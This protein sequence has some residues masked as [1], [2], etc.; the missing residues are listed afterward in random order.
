MQTLCRNISLDGQ[1]IMEGLDCH[2][3]LANDAY[4]PKYKPQ[5]PVQVTVPCTAQAGLLAAGKIEDP[6]FEM[7]NE[8]ILW[9]EEKEWWYFR[10]FTVPSDIKGQRYQLVF[11][12]ITYRA[13]VFLDGITVGKLEGTFLRF[14]ID[15]TKFA[16]PGSTH[17]LA[18]RLRALEDSSKDRPGGEVKRGMVRSSGVVPPFSYWWNW[19]P[20]LVPVGI[21]KSVHL[22]IDGGVEIR[23]PYVQTKIS[24]DECIEAEYADITVSVDA[25]CSLKRSEDIV[26][27]G[28]IKGDGFDDGE[29]DLREFYTI[30][31]GFNGK[32]VIKTRMIRPRL[33]WP[34]GMG[35]HPLYT[36]ELRVYDREGN[37]L[38][39]VSTEFGVREIT[40]EKNPDDQWTLET[41]KQSNRLWSYVGNP[42]PWIYVVN[43]K[44]MFVR[45]SNW[46]PMDNM[47]RFEE[48]RY[49]TYLDQIEDSNLNLLRVWAGGICETETFYRICNR[50]GILCWAETWFSCSNYP[51]MSHDLFIENAIDM[52]KCIRNHPS[53]AMWS[54]GNEYNPDAPENKDLVDKIGEAVKQYDPDRRFRRGSPYKG[55]R[56]GGLLILPTRTSNKYNG[57]ILNGDQRLTIFRAEVAIARSVPCVESL[58]KFLGEDHLWPLD[59]P[60]TKEIWQYHHAVIKEEE[61]DAKEYGCTDSLER[62][63]MSTQIYHG[64]VHRHNMEHCRLTKWHNSGCMQWQAQA[65]WPT[66]HR[67]MIDWYGLPKAVFFMYKRSSLD[68]LV[69]VDMEKYVFDGNEPM[70]ASVWAVSDRMRNT[71]TSTVT[72][73]IYSLDMQLMHEQEATINLPEN[74]SVKAFDIDWTV[75][76]NYLRKVLFIHVELRRNG[77]LLADNFYWVGTSR[78]SRKTKSL[79]LNGPWDW[80]VNKE[81]NPA[82][83]KETIMPSYWALPQRAPTEKEGVVFYQKRVKIPA[84]WKGT[85]LEVFGQGFEGNDV[86]TFNGVEI[87]KTEEEMTIEMRPDD[88]MFTEM[89]AERQRKLGKDVKEVNMGYEEGIKATNKIGEPTKKGD[90]QNVRIA[91]DPITI[92]N[93]IKRFYSIPQDKVNYGGWNLLS[94]KLYG[95]HATGISEP[96]FI[97]EASSADEQR[98]IIE[99]DNDGDYLSDLNNLKK[100]DLDCGV[101]CDKTTVKGTS[102][103][104]EIVI[105]LENNTP[106]VS[107]YTELKCPGYNEDIRMLY[108]DNYFEVLP[109]QRKRITAK[110]RNTVGFKGKKSLQFS[111]TGWNAV[112]KPIG[113][114]IEITF[115]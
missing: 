10:E 12:G 78:Y 9:I 52:I 51:V 107:F 82:H 81:I 113:K 13:D 58:K 18:L 62:W 43:K 42:Y 108:S 8:K 30:E 46:V 93:L 68:Y 73:R 69:T 38:D 5:D 84:D 23:D 48:E 71:G 77:G 44:R 111:V 104:T 86:V 67:E 39:T 64:I 56:H 35:S 80:Q 7:N 54:G 76:A 87:G 89:W 106:D 79:C 31:P 83:W 55:D 66:M 110:I 101:Y 45:G 97:R 2:E 14:F 24:W 28:T 33:W 19:S 90:K 53:V 70:V 102:G 6:Y 94:V 75:P 95:D 74:E 50:K 21:W 61:K 59:D 4:K 100:V 63:I 92:P 105:I 15:I 88:L 57:D 29:I 36:L 99:I 109:D 60:K 47:L 37:L 65:S 20:H 103:T 41:S 49:L 11:E 22:K 112:A 85:Q 17:K 25:R 98:A 91:A 114:P 96:V 27:K 72:A 32:F 1:W 115:E 16:R 40:F 3:G 34:N 26:I